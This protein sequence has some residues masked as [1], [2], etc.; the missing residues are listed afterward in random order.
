MNPSRYSQ[1]HALIDRLLE[2]RWSFLAVFTLVF[3][4]SYLFLVAIDLVP[5]P[6]A[7]EINTEI[8]DNQS[9]QFDVINKES[10]KI[11]DQPVEPINI[12]I[13]R[14]DKNIT[15]LNPISRSVT[16]LDNALLSGVVRHPDSAKLGQAG[17]VFILGHSSYLPTVLNRNFQAFNGIQDLEWGDEIEVSSKDKVFVY[18]VDKVYRAEAQELVVPIAGEENKLTLATCDS[19]GAVNDRFIVEATQIEERAL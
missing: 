9:S 10:V 12:Y 6:V 16:D 19:F 3:L 11:P 14:L 8:T 5:E 18:R 7:K 13:K 2:R 15:V 4:L 1:T 17:N